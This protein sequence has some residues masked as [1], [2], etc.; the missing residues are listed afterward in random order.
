MVPMHHSITMELQDWTHVNFVEPNI[1]IKHMKMLPKGLF[2]FT[3]ESIENLEGVEAI[4]QQFNEF[5]QL[6]IVPPPI[7]TT[8]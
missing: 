7:E 8:I 2:V 6:V 3:F 1:F 4:L 5:G